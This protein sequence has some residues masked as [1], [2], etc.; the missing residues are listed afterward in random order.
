MRRFVAVCGI[1]CLAIL[2]LATTAA[3]Q[4]V[5]ALIDFNDTLHLTPIALNEY[6]DLGILFSADNLVGGAPRG[7]TCGVSECNGP[8]P[9]SGANSAAVNTAGGG[10]EGVLTV[11]FVGPTSGLP[12]TVADVGVYLSDTEFSVGVQALDKDGAELFSCANV[13][14]GCPEVVGGFN[15]A[16]ILLFPGP[17]IAQLKLIDSG[18]DGHIVDDLT[19]D[20]DTPGNKDDCKKG[21][22][23]LYGFRNQGQCIRFVNTGKDSR[24]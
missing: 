13:F 1:A 11:T 14:F 10:P 5:T 6:A 3:A 22:W 7:Y 24:D 19:F 16:R 15:R 17:G 21:G 23:V 8:Y 18:G 2:A 9:A 12:A 4:P 20:Y